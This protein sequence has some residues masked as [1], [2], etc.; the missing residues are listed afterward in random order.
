MNG[1]V[2]PGEEVV[3]I[4][5]NDLPDEESEENRNRQAADRR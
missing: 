2:A 3:M 1:L 5:M 4:D